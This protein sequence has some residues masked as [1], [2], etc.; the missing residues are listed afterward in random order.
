MR[1]GPARRAAGRWRWRSAVK[2]HLVGTLH[3]DASRLEAT[4]FG[5]TKPTQPNTTAAG[6]QTNRRVE[7]VKLP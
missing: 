3:V 6:R 4:G 2:A 1:P 5:A 7:L